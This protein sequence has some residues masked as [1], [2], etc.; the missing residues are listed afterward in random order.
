MASLKCWIVEI[1]KDQSV[2]GPIQRNSIANQTGQNRH[3]KANAV[4]SNP[5]SVRRIVFF[6]EPSYC[7]MEFW[8]RRMVEGPDLLSVFVFEDCTPDPSRLKSVS[9]NV[10]QYCSFIR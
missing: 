10:E 8:S 1:R 3:V 4:V 5:D 9:L 7:V 6:K 2:N